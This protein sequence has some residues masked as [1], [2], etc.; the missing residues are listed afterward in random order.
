MAKTSAVL[1][2]ILEIE[3]T[4]PE[5]KRACESALAPVD[6]A[7]VAFARVAESRW[8]NRSEAI[9]EFAMHLEMLRTMLQS[10]IEV[11]THVEF[12]DEKGEPNA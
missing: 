9:Q 12:D 6:N 4:V 1:R 3:Q 8:A 7:I 11:C 10:T 2:D 5:L